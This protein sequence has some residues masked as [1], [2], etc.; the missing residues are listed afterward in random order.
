MV[1][2]KDIYPFVKR[3]MCFYKKIYMVLKNNIY[4]LQKR[5]ICFQIFIR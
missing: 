5:Y 4:T 2:Q 3:Y 1:L